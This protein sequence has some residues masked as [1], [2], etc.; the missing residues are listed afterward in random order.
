M[1][2]NYTD[3]SQRAGHIAVGEMYLSKYLYYGKKVYYLCPRMCQADVDY[4]DKHKRYDK[5]W[6]LLRN[7]DNVVYLT[8]DNLVGLPD[9]VARKFASISDLPMKG[10]VLRTYTECIGIMVRGIKSGEITIKE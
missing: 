1:K 7:E 3:G 5:E 4:L 6:A 2:R 8:R 9:D 10:D